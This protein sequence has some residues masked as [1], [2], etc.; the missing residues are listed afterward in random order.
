MGRM[1]LLQVSET[2]MLIVTQDDKIIDII[3]DGNKTTEWITKKHKLT[4]LS[5]HL[6]AFIY[7]TILE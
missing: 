5:K 4:V 7:K 3:N 1:R 6:V 2:V